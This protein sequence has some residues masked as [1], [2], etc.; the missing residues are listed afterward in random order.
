MSAR[1]SARVASRRSCS[2]GWRAEVSCCLSSS[3]FFS[4]AERGL[5]F[6]VDKPALS[7]FDAWCPAGFSLKWISGMALRQRSAH[8]S[9]RVR[10]GSV[11]D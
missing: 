2:W 10:G 7:S 6:E 1:L 8:A 9:A 4:T 3:C 5:F 11:D